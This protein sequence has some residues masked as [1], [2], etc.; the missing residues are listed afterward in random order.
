MATL[1]KEERFKGVLSHYK[2]SY[3][4]HSVS[5]RT[6]DRVFF[7]LLVTVALFIVQSHDHTIVEQ[8]IN[9]LV[10]KN[11]GDQVSVINQLPVLLWFFLAAM[12]LRYFQVN[13]QIQNQ[14]SY[15]H[16][17][18]EEINKFYPLSVAFTREGRSYR[19][20]FGFFS[21]WM[22]LLYNWLFP[23]GLLAAVINRIYTDINSWPPTYSTICCFIAYEVC[24]T[25]I[26]LYLI[27]LHWKK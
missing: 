5:I 10:K 13:L 7:Y 25:S 22:W 16:K 8:I 18:E 12:S 17:L 26:V 4:V 9:A 1:S 6:R 3:D 20:G 24:G 2:D 14:Y 27:R 19:S 21:F 11:L 15:L 23:V